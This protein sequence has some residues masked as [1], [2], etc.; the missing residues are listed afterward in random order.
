MSGNLA[1]PRPDR[2]FI[3]AAHREVERKSPTLVYCHTCRQ[4]NAEEWFSDVHP[5]CDISA[6]LAR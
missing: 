6:A 3:I 1:L 5:A 2:L 4:C